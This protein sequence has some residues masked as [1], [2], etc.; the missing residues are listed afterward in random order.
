MK[1]LYVIHYPVFG[2]PHN[3]A[4]VLAG[5]LEARGLST[6][7]LLPEFDGIDPGN[8][9]PR[10]RA[11]GVDVVTTP[12]DRIRATLDP[13]R[14]LAFLSHLPGDVRRIRRIIR[15]R[16]IDVVQLGGFMNPH[17]ALA[18]RLE[19]RAVVWQLLDTRPPMSARRLLMPLVVNLSDV[20]MTTGQ[21]VADVHP[22]AQRLDERLRIY[23][24]PV[25]PDRFDPGQID[26][27]TARQTFGFAPDEDV[28]C[29][30]GNLNPQKGHEYLLEAAA[31][32]RSR[33]VALKVLIVGA[34]HS[35]HH[36]YEQGLYAL[37]RRHAMTPGRDVIF[38]GALDDVR[39]ALA[40]SDV[41]V[42]ASVPRSEGT[43]TAIEE[44]MMMGLP[45]VATDVGAV[46]EIVDD[47]E[48]GFVVP[49]LDASR[50]A[51]A[52]VRMIESPA[53]RDD[54]GRSARTRARA[55][56]SVEECVRVHVDSY[57]RALERRSGMRARKKRAS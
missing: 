27:S 29:S 14:Q 22:G 32:V 18:A 51:E 54:F 52:L 33:G 24:P 20:V 19:D 7:V 13:R 21:A 16:S 5:P 31:L 48:N 39:P 12:L 17:G 3:Q 49:A 57:E 28:V 23:F 43:P 35:T 34:S 47:G 53:L 25:D 4:A 44:A 41:F 42:L 30:V 1:I 45:I 26:R 15:E 2:G 6:T 46:R 50:L 40:A 10:L 38:T 9:A 37:C 55:R 36:A 11:A 8:A 56:F